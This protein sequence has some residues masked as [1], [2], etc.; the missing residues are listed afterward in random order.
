LDL[1]PREE[2][3]G[4]SEKKEARVNEKRNRIGLPRVYYSKLNA[5]INLKDLLRKVKF[6]YDLR[7]IN[8][9]FVYEKKNGSE[10]EI[11]IWNKVS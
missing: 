6:S 5:G 2:E 8:G 3:S 4:K 10:N 9:L 1:T 7:W 11:R